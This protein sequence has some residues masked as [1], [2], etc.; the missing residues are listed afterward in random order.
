MPADS[1]SIAVISG[2]GVT[3]R[4]ENGHSETIPS[5]WLRLHCNYSELSRPEDR[6][7]IVPGGI[8]IEFVEGPSPVAPPQ[9]K[10]EFIIS[11]MNDDSAWKQGRAG[12]QYRDLIPGSL[13][14]AVIASHIRIPEGGE[15]PDYVHYHRVLF[16]MIYCK[17][18]WARLVYEDQ[19]PPF[20]MNAGDFVLQPPRVRHRVLETSA[21]F[22]VIEVGCPAV[23]ETFADHD[24]KLPTPGKQPDRLFSGQYFLHDKAKNSE[25]IADE[26]DGCEVWQTG[27]MEATQGL[28]DVHLVRNLSRDHAY[29]N[30]RSHND[31]V[32]LYV[33]SGYGDICLGEK[34]RYELSEGDCCSLPSPSAF[35]IT[36]KKGFCMLIVSLEEKV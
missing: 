18:G 30:G 4:L 14:G 36:G 23:H 13:G 34:D 15:T 21:G 25:W 8:Q 6:Q 12:M 19:G 33:L 2:Y 10:P 22:E 32:I 31:I 35:Q 11:R 28:A 5:S 16:Q 7:I 24:M 1:P 9:W 27:I 3:V 17:S 20:I 26:I 29:F